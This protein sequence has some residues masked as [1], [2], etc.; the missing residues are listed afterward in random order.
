MQAEIVDRG[1]HGH[2]HH[3]GTMDHH[4]GSTTAL[5]IDL[6]SSSALDILKLKCAA[7]ASCCA[8]AAIPVQH[9]R[10]ES[11][12]V[13]FTVVSVVRGPAADFVVSRPTPPPRLSLA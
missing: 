6:D 12:H 3:P 11:V 9:V 7:C 4:A 5:D 10:I 2:A 8:S 1:G 13:S